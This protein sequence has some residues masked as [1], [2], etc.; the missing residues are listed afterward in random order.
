[1]LV[2]RTIRETHKQDLIE[3]DRQRLISIRSRLDRLIKKCYSPFQ[4]QP[5]FGKSK[6][7]PALFLARIK[8][9]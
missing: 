8:N 2:I 1:M 5:I 4:F 6:K 7:F 9:D 3:L